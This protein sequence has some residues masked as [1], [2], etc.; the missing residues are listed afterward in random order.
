MNRK[1]LL[2]LALGLSSFALPTTAFAQS[3]TKIAVDPARQKLAEQIADKLIAPGSYQKMMKD[4]ADQMAGSMIEQMMGMD[5]ATIAKSVGESGKA[6]E[7]KSLGE[8]ASEVDPNFKERMDIMMKVMFDEMGKLMGAMEPGARTAMAK[9]YARKYDVRQLTDM[10]TFFATPSGSTFAA[11][12]F[13]TFTDKEMINA[14]MGEMP[15]L[16]DA[17]PMIMKKVE[18]AT[19]HLP[20]AP[21]QEVATETSGVFAEDGVGPWNDSENWSA[22]D[23]KKF[24]ALEKQSVQANEKADAIDIKMDEVRAAAIQSS[25]AR[26]VA[27]GYKAP[28]PEPSPYDKEGLATLKKGW[29]KTDVDAIDAMAA[30]YKAAEEAANNAS[31]KWYRLEALMYSA[32]Q[33]AMVNAGQSS[34]GRKRSIKEAVDEASR[35]YDENRKADDAADAAAAAAEAAAK[36]N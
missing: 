13:S 28:E 17:M 8:L 22:S 29:S 23:R 1:F 21:R 32:Y 36:A 33:Q 9:V 20:P 27:E 34:D 18:A 30:L 31:Q 15:K 7:G 35:A 10:N 2:A 4:M 6:V 25:K 14:M 3:A 19:A 16:L 11:D 24:E 12:F 5:A 26:Y